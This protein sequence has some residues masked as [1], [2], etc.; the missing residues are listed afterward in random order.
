MKKGYLFLMVLISVIL[1]SG[2]SC[3]RN[4]KSGGAF[5]GGNQGL[6]ANFLDDAPPISGNFQ[7]QNFPID[8]ELINKGETEI[9]QGGAI[10]YL[11]GALYS[12]G[13]VSTTVQQASNLEFINGLQKSDNNLVEDSLIVSL[14]DARYN[15]QIL[16]DTIPLEVRASVCYP[17][18]TKVQVEDFC[19]PST[20]RVADS[21]ECNVD[22][23]INI[24]KE[25]E[26]SGAPVHV[27]SVREQA[28][29]D[30]VRV[31]LDINNVGI[32]QV[33]NVCQRE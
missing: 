25:N 5:L 22:S 7:N 3:E 10:V 32:G 27:S 1:V 12:S 29:P 28:G 31:T 21:G 2:Q 19:I 4:S 16:G 8:I 15:G 20:T 26:N 9:G 30:F 6:A 33:V 17:Y 23:T 11:T 14:G 18:E 13:A 24:I